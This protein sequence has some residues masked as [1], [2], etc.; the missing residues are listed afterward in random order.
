[1]KHARLDFDRI[2][3]A[4]R[5]HLPELVARWLPA[6]RRD[7]AL[8]RCGSIHGTPGQSLAITIVGPKAGRFRDFADERVR[9]SDAIAL[10][11]AVFNLSQFE[12]AT[13]I[14]QMLGIEPR[15]TL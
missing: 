6:G 2:A 15:A 1:M 12:A 4:A 14:A 7:G 13:R 11:A 9:G 5:P 3:E 8:W 10:A